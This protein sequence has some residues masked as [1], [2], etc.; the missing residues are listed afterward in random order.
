[1]CFITFCTNLL[2]C[3]RTLSQVIFIY[4]LCIS[5]VGCPSVEEMHNTRMSKSI[6]RKLA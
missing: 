1:M 5:A 3:P 2:T 4:E 6:P